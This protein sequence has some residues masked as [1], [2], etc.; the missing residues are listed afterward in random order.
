MSKYKGIRKFVV[1]DKNP[2]WDTLNLKTR[3]KNIIAGPAE[4]IIVNKSTNEV[5]GHTAFMKFQTVDKEKF[6]K[7]FTE[8]V[9]SLFD[10]SRPAIR[11]FCYVLDRAKPNIDQIIFDLEDAK[12]FTGYTSKGTIF[13]G[14]SELIENRIIA[15]SKQYYIYYINPN[16]FFN[17]DRVSFVRSFRVEP[18]QAE[19]QQAIEAA[20]PKDDGETL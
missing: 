3:K 4:E 19:E 20:R 11:V 10:L 17:G 7:V 6:V 8:N 9:S 16:I 5:T 2:F 15:R 18:T 14:V 1:N 13:K 12:E